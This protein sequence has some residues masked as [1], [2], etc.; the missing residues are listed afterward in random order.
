MLK[1]PEGATHRKFPVLHS[2]G[3]LTPCPA[4][5]SLPNFQAHNGWRDGREVHCSAVVKRDGASVTGG[6]SKADDREK[7]SLPWP[8][9]MPPWLGYILVLRGRLV[10]DQLQISM[11]NPAEP[12]RAGPRKYGKQARVM[13]WVHQTVRLQQAQ[14]GGASEPAPS[15]ESRARLA[16]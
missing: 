14:H 6:P 3:N 15:A 13:R 11:R 16:A 9:N 2:V 7:L 1:A 8:S 10:E 4:A 12:N 5:D